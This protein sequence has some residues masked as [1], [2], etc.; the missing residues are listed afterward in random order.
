[1]YFYYLF[2][3]VLGL[4]V[5]SFLNVVTARWPRGRSLWGRSVCEHCHHPLAFHDLIPLF[6]WFWLRGRCRYCHQRLSWQEPLVE[7]ATGLLFLAV[8]FSGKAWPGSAGPGPS[9]SVVA[10]LHFFYWFFIV[11]ALMVIFVVDL[12]EGVVLEAV[13]FPAIVVAFLDRVLWGGNRL[14]TLYLSLQNDVAGLG[15]YLLRTNFLRDRF[16]E[17]LRSLTMTLL[18]AALIALIFWLIIKVTHGRGMGLGDVWLGFLVG[19]IT[20]FPEVLV[21][22]FLAFVLGALV[23]LGLLLAGKKRWG[24]TVPFGPFLSAAT[25]LTLFFGGKLFSWYLTLL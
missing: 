3:F 10:L 25:L 22:V 6:S 18:A 16:W 1:M 15:P 20:G 19:L 21:A 14:T 24:E 5:G 11:A 4:C 2:V 13:V 12:K 9:F 23:S 8:V 17:E 7:L